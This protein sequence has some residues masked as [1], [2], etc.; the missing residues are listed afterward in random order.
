MKHLQLNTLVLAIGFIIASC[1]GAVTAVVPAPSPLPE[2][3][4]SSLALAVNVPDA[5][6]YGLGLN[7]FEAVIMVINNGYQKTA[8]ELTVYFW[9][10]WQGH[11]P[12]RPL[13]GEV[14]W[15][16]CNVDQ[17]SRDGCKIWWR[18]E[19]DPGRNAVLIVPVLYALGE[20]IMNYEVLV[21]SDGYE[22]KEAGKIE[23]K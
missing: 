5:V 16:E 6:Q 4:T 3:P 11:N 10:M 1:G 17:N 18:A 13:D 12:V 14:Y 23:I 21:K 2:A 7:G 15:E 8:F 22:K 9:D 20:G 19:V